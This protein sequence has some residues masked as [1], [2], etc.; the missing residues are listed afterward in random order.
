MDPPS[1]VGI[2]SMRRMSGAPHHFI[3]DGSRRLDARKTLTQ[4]L[5]KPAITSTRTRRPEAFASLWRSAPADFS[6]RPMRRAKKRCI[7]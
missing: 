1:D 4:I 2:S 6:P 3:R 7:A 5:Q